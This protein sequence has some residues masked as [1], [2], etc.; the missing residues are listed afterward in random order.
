[1][2]R[3]CVSAFRA[4]QATNQVLDTLDPRGLGDVTRLQKTFWTVDALPQDVDCGAA[5]SAVFCS[6]D[7]TH[8]VAS[9]NNRLI[10]TAG[11]L[12]E[13]GGRFF[14]FAVVAISNSRVLCILLIQLLQR[15]WYD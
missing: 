7:I 13:S 1:M 3:Y 10:E 4:I 8:N 9:S 11:M 14:F 2:R 6:L 12:Q 5:L 15:L